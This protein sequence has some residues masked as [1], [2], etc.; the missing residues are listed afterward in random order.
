MKRNEIILAVD[1]KLFTKS[2]NDDSI[3]FK[4]IFV[5]AHLVENHVKIQKTNENSPVIFWVCSKIAQKLSESLF[6]FMFL[7]SQFIFFIFFLLNFSLSKFF[8]F[9]FKVWEIHWFFR[10][11]HLCDKTFCFLHDKRLKL[12]IFF[13]YFIKIFRNRSEVVQK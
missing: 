11:T 3:M 10:K 7:Q 9:F 2:A 6:I 1:V 12:T 8:F 4:V 13:M 5:Y